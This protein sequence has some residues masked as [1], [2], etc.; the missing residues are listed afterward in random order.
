MLME[1]AFSS[2]EAEEDVARGRQDRVANHDPDLAPIRDLIHLRELSDEIKVAD[3][4]LEYKATG[5]LGVPDI[6]VV[7]REGDRVAIH[8]GRAG[9]FSVAQVGNAPIFPSHTNAFE[10]PVVII[11][12]RLV[13]LCYLAPVVP[14]HVLD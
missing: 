10:A 12:S 11:A 8:L 13:P 3:D 5:I 6:V 14:A 7:C 2:G 9:A 4:L 1:Y